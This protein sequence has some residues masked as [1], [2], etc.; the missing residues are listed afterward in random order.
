MNFQYHAQ[1]NAKSY[2]HANTYVLVMRPQGLYL[3]RCLVSIIFHIR[4]ED[5]I[6]LE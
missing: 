1:Q 3:N 2:C 6:S 5:Q 4:A